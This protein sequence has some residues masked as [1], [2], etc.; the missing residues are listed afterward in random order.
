[1]EHISLPILRLVEQ[2]AVDANTI[3]SPVEQI[4]SPVT[5]IGNDRTKLES[6]ASPFNMMNVS[7]HTTGGVHFASASLEQPPYYPTAG[8]N[9]NN[10][11]STMNY[12]TNNTM[13]P[14]GIQQ[15]NF[16]QL[17]ANNMNT[18]NNIRSYP[19]MMETGFAQAKAEQPGGYRQSI[20]SSFSNTMTND[21][22]NLHHPLPYSMAQSLNNATASSGYPN[23]NMLGLSQAG[24]QFVPLAVDPAQNFQQQPTPMSRAPGS[25]SSYHGH[26]PQ[27][28][29]YPQ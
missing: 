1:M 2:R 20:E 27:H 29:Y 11:D 25:A 18:I 22:Y 15:N 28:V 13:Y 16:D 23:S 17:E 8:S 7:P 3:I 14:F 24:Y 10:L 26:S 12:Q 9:Y 19:Q 6:S 4:V 5:P 21:S